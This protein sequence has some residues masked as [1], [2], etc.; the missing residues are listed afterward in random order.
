MFVPLYEGFIAGKV[1]MGKK[2]T[3]SK[4]ETLQDF[5]SYILCGDIFQ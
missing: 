5:T 3:H 4:N 1:T 2:R